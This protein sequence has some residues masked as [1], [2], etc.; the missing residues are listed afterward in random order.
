MEKDGTASDKFRI[1]SAM[2]TD[3]QWIGDL[4]TSEWGGDVMV[5]RGRSRRLADAV[6]LVAWLGEERVG[7][8]TYC[9]DEVPT[10]ECEL[11]S[12]NAVVENRGVGT[13]LL[14]AVEDRAREAGCPRTVIIT[15][16]DNLAALRFYQR[17]GY[18]IAAVHSGAIDTA[19]IQKPSIPIIGN[20]GIEI[21]D[22]VE[23]MRNLT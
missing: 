18:R 6:A 14:K 1:S 12:L 19:R 4:W 23:L 3:A 7:L 5:S 11:L 10:L 22:E 16:N 9:I 15:S 8:A 2:A 21:H 13:A 20:D 17:R